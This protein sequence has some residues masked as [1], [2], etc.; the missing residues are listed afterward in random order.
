MKFITNILVLVFFI[1]INVNSQSLLGVKICVDPGH[2]GYDA[3]NDRFIAATGFWESE[4]NWDKALHLKQMLI[5]LGAFVYMTRSGNTNNDDPGLSVRAAVANNNNVDIFHSIHSN[6]FQGTS[7]YSLM[8]FKGTDNA[9]ANPA[10]KLYGERVGPKIY[11]A[12]RTTALYNRGDMSFL[13]YNLGD[14]NPLN[15]QGVLSEGSFHD[16]IPESWRLLN[17]YYR[18]HEALAITRGL[19]LHLNGGTLQTGAIAG[20]VRDPSKTVT[21]YAF[22]G[23]DQKVPINNIKITIQPG[24]LVFNGDDKNNGFYLFNDLLPGQ[25]KVIFE[26][27]GFFKDSSTVS[28][29]ANQTVFADK[30]INFDTTIAPIVDSYY[31]DPSIDSVKTSDVVKIKFSRPMNRATVESSFSMNPSTTGTFTWTSD[32]MSFTFKP[33]LPYQPK[34]IYT[35]TLTPQALSIWNVGLSENFSFSFSTKFRNRLNIENSYPNENSIEIST[36][37]QIRLQFDAPIFQGSLAGNVKLV[38]ELGTQQTVANVKVTSVEGKGFIYFEP[39]YPLNNNAIYTVIL[40][41][42]ITDTDSIPMVDTVYI[43][44]RTTTENYVFGNVIDNFE[45]IGGWRNP[46]ISENSTGIDTSIS[47][48]AITNEK[49]VTGSNSGRLIYQFTGSNGI[50]AVPNLTKPSIGSNTDSKV[51]LWVFGDLSMNILEYFFADAQNNTVAQFVDTISWTGWKIKYFPIGNILLTGEKFLTELSVKQTNIGSVSGTIYLD[52]FQ[53]D[54]L[55]NAKEDQ[56]EIP[57]EFVL[58]QNYPNP[59]NPSTIIDWQIP[60]A[61]FVTLKIYD[62]LGNEVATLINDYKS[63]GKYTTEFNT[64][65]FN[66]SS[67]IYF[68]SLT[69]QGKVYTKKLLLLK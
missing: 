8:L 26:R 20:I 63:A 69:T 19:L 15:M 55:V 67:G 3:A 56:F 32:N 6:G 11:A 36:T 21:Y 17:T 29:V 39:K 27:E 31:P 28:V 13:G 44:F 14:L 25:Y 53:N 49:K 33:D 65:K 12:H 41:G 37:V 59:F 5:D 60:S 61:G 18:K 47:K 38:D 2:G 46:N 23:N 64:S 62:V 30:F 43:N 10:S 24:D 57:N 66:L 42:K 52:D 40:N 9:P 58:N 45:T 16:Y 34:Q 4:G 1:A 22:P 50:A 35:V 54:I 68:Y 7:N 48:F 51:G